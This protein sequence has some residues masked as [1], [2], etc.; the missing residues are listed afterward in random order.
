MK[1]TG[2]KGTRKLLTGEK[3]DDL[4]LSHKLG[5][6]DTHCPDKWV[7]VDLESGNV[8][9]WDVEKGRWK[10]PPKKALKALLSALGVSEV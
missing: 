1:K 7:F 6:I 9:A 5:Q 8:Y 3:V 2:V 10:S 4:V